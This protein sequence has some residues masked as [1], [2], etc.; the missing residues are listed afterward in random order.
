MT[1]QRMRISRWILKA[2]DTHSEYVTHIAFPLQ[3]WLRE[4]ASVLRHMCIVCIVITETQYIF[5]S[6]PS[7]HNIYKSQMHNYNWV[8]IGDMFRPLNDHPQ[9]N[10]AQLSTRLL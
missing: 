1:I 7:I 3:Q 2:T 9:A 6:V 8:I 10:L 4:R 5:Q